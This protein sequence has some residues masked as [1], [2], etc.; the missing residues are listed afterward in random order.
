MDTRVDNEIRRKGSRSREGAWGQ[1]VD[2][3]KKVA[4]EGKG[5]TI[6]YRLK[7]KKMSSLEMRAEEDLDVNNPGAGEKKGATEGRKTMDLETFPVY[8]NPSQ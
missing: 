5:A 3:V 6:P 2:R 1:A 8:H 4:D 7:A